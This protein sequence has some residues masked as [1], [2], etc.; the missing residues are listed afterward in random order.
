MANKT[1]GV[2]EQNHSI[3]QSVSQRYAKAVTNG[4]QLCCPT[5]YNHEDLGK[6][7]PE[8][9]LKVS[10]GCG[11]PVGLSTVQSGEVV[12]DIGSGGGI[13]CFEASRKVGPQGRVIGIDMTDEMLALARTH[14]PT[15]AKNLG[16]PEPNVDFRKGFA[17]AMPVGDDQVDLIIS[18]CVINLAPDKKK[19]FRE[20]FRVLR[21][22]GRFTISDIVADQP[23]PNYLIH[24]KAKWGDC[25]SGALTIKDYWGGLRD[26]GFTGLHQ[27]TGIPWRVIDGIHFVSV[28][29][30]GYKLAS[31][32]STPSPAF[33]TL[34][35]PFSQVVD[36]MGTTFYRGK[37]Q[38]ID[39][40]TASLFA[41]A[42]YKDRFIVA[43]R[44]LPLSSQDSRTIAIYPEEAPCVWEGQ[45]AVLTGPFLAVCDD[46]HHTYRCGEPLEICSKTFNVLQSPSYQ[47]YFA[48]INRA[49]EGVTSEPVICGTSTGC[50]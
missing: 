18:N 20:M 4:E 2:E 37:P 6:F 35:G 8:P 21:P 10:Y 33:A 41:L 14:A 48:T 26:A 23:I 39:V 9:V 46:D 19:V 27:V 25:L 44:P 22:G 16:Y 15:V 31:T 47:P 30:T 50:C 45:F 29:L 36:E 32:S 40:R 17:D 3:T 1:V 5:G 49:R 13:D 38:Q 11:T 7:I 42:P 34:T 24:D 12:L 28:T 43:E